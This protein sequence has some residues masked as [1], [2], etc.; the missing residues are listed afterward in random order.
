MIESIMIYCELPGVAGSRASQGMDDVV[1]EVQ[2]R[3][4]AKT[5]DFICICRR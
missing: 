4:Q 3:K 1:R 2:E 5:C